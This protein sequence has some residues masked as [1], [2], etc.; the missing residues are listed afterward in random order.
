MSGEKIIKPLK[1]P[2]P[3]AKASVGYRPK[4]LSEN[5]V[6]K[7]ALVVIPIEAIKKAVLSESR[8]LSRRLHSVV[9]LYLS[10]FNA[11]G[12]IMYLHAMQVLYQLSYGPIREFWQLHQAI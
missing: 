1:R 11:F 7:R 2:S 10:Y 4:E 8:R 6:N 12:E 5:S 9:R 3:P